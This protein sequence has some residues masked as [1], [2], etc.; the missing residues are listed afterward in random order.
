[1]SVRYNYQCQ[2]CHG[3]VYNANSVKRCKCCNEAVCPTC[4]TRGYCVKCLRITTSKDRRRYDN[5]RQQETI[6]AFGI[7]ALFIVIPFFAPIVINL[8]LK[9]LPDYENVSNIL[10]I[11][12]FIAIF[13]IVFILFWVAQK[14]FK[15]KKKKARD[16]MRTRIATD[17]KLSVEGGVD[18]NYDYYY[19]SECNKKFES[20]A[21]M[22]KHKKDKHEIE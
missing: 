11:V 13:P 16:Q 22:L 2:T 8:L 1:M 19:C 20:V 3:T 5:I 6:T 7:L 9:S 18:L 15:V 4:A 12:T 14:K 17:L 10:S 21:D